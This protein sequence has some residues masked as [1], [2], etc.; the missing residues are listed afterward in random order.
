MQ[1][2]NQPNAGFSPEGVKT[3]LPVNPNYADGINVSDQ[4][5]D[6][7]SHLNFY[8]QLIALRKSAP[9]L[10]DGDYCPLLENN[11]DVCAFT[12]TS[13]S[14]SQTCLVLLNMSENF[15]HLNLNELAKGVKKLYSSIEGKQT[16]ISL[17]AIQLNAFEIFI[18]ELIH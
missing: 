13:A 9:A 11:P 12:R 14:T 17:N 6:P 1:W 18:G 4:L 15:H 2:S 16:E 3:W 10:M 7:A 8:K 5:S